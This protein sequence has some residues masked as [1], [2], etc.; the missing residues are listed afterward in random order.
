[1]SNSHI[2]SALDTTNTTVTDAT[3][4]PLE[5]SKVGVLTQDQIDFF[6]CN[7][8]LPYKKILTDKEIDLYRSQYD[9][10]FKLAESNGSWRNL[11]AAEGASHTE[12]K[13]HSLQMLQII[14]MCERNI[15]FM[16]LIYDTRILD[17]VQD[18]LGPNIMLFHDQALYK[19]AFHGGEVTWHQ[20]NSYWKC[21]PANLISC[22]LT[23]DD[24]VVENGA[25]QVI[26]GS[27]LTPVWHTKKN[28]KDILFNIEDQIDKSKAVGVPLPAGACMFHHCQTFH[29]TQPNTTN[30][31]R[32]A[33]A[34]HFMTPGTIVGTGT[35]L[36]VGIKHPMLRAAL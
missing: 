26:P 28:E 7:G 14:Q 24:V 13:Q 20:D 2:D 23:L 12:Q 11:S 30:R 8:Y 10:E 3:A 34:I 36:E 6:F 18:L 15:H 32:R 4:S 35:K 17:V 29:Y 9:L 22:W 5:P 27:H 19:P 1:M 25:M 16:K 31:Q 33:F 21:R